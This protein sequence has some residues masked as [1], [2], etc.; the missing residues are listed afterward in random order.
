MLAR[1]R[2]SP[3][4]L[5]LRAAGAAGFLV[6]IQARGDP[7]RVETMPSQPMAHACLNTIAPSSSS[8]VLDQADAGLYRR[9]AV[10]SHFL[11]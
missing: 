3:P 8:K 9:A 11:S 4:P 5:S 2:S 1:G 7:S 6:L 10:P